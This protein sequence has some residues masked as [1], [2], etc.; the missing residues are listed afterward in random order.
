MPNLEAEFA[1]PMIRLF[2]IAAGAGLAA[3]PAIA[4]P[5]HLFDTGAGHS[6]LLD[7]ALIAGAGLA[8]LG[9]GIAWI[10]RRLVTPRPT[11]RRC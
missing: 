5:G 8:A 9:W 3:A 11:S 6:H 4:H 7:A 1:T 10:V 2:T